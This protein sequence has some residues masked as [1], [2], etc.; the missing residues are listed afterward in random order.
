MIP[1]KGNKT[2]LSKEQ[3]IRGL[4]ETGLKRNDVVLVHSAM[5]TFGYI[6][7]GAE[8][9]TRLRRESDL[10]NQYDRRS[11]PSHHLLQELQVDKCLL[12]I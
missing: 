7:G 4:R 8:T 1:S 11:A 6:E 9:V 5:R 10:R 3:I 12:K 2:G